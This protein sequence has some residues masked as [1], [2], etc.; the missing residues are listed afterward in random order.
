[1][2]SQLTVRGLIKDKDYDVIDGGALSV[3]IIY[4]GSSFKQ[5]SWQ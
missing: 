3:Q 2:P 5:Y 4:L 1:M